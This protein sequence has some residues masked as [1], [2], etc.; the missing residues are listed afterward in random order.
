MFACVAYIGRRI[1]REIK[2]PVPLGYRHVACRCGM[3]P[4]KCGTRKKMDP[5]EL[6]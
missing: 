6:I 1:Q 4:V 3:I 2:L 5:K